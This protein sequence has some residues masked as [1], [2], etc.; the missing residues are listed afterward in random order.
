RNCGKPLC[1]QCAREV[2][3]ALYCEECLSR[4]VTG[5]SPAV[6]GVSTGPN[7]GVAAALGF[8]PGLGAVYNGEYIKG[9]IHVV[10]F[11]GLI[12]ILNSDTVSGG[13]EAMVAVFFAAFC[14]YMPIEAYRTARAKQLGQPTPGFFGEAESRQPIGAFVLIGLGVLFLLDTLGFL[15]SMWISRLWPLVLVAVGVLLIWKRNRVPS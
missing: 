13:M 9:V 4:M 6:P 7:P 5:P 2:R 10:I 12:G 8:I 15:S 11:G 14:C 3:G 1:A